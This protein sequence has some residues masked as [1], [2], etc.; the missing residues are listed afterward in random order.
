MSSFHPKKRKKETPMHNIN[1][2]WNGDPALLEACRRDAQGIRAVDDFKAWTRN[3][4][5]PLLLHGAL[6]CVHGRTHSAG[7]SVDY[8]VTVDYPLE[9][10][11][12]I[13]NTSGHM[14]SPLARCWF[15]QKTPVFFD[16][17]KPPA[18]VSTPWLT[19]FRKHGLRN[20]AAD[21]VLDEPRCIATY[22]S[23]HQLP[24]LDEEELRGTLK[25]LIPL[26]HETFARVIHLHQEKSA[27]L[28]CNYTGLTT[29]EQEI[30]AHISQGKSNVQIASVL[31]VSEFTV[32][33]HISRIL[34]KTGCSNR[35]A[36][37]TASAAHE[38][39][40]FGMGTKIL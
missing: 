17:G 31:G 8:V 18:Y 5:R 16:A 29:R 20:A 10:L 27:S 22:F 35:A 23:F 11:Q 32:R 3:S 26:L 21:G 14:D 25:V 4:V 1:P 13:R 36:L 40:R 39:E 34:Q 6:A 30:I 12:D 19:S 33:N 2:P 37:A 24:T 15:E 28:A 7:I 38:N 9:H